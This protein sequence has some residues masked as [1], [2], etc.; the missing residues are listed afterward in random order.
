MRPNFNHLKEHNFRRGFADTIN[1]RCP[2]R[3]DVETMEHFLL[4]C[5]FYST[6][7]FELFNNLERGNSDFKNLSGKDQ[8]SFMLYHSKTN[9][10]ENFNHN[11]IKIVIK[12]L[13]KTGHFD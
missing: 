3:A 2:Y 13:K 5:H 11:I 1:S 8:V 9:N 6:Q 4:R 10:Y 7:R 12:Y